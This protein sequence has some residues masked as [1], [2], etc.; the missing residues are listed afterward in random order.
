LTIREL[1]EGRHHA[2]ILT[3]TA[4]FSSEETRLDVTLA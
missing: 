2:H 1:F 4:R 3:F